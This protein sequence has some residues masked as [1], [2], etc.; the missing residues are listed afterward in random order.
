MGHAEAWE[1]YFLSWETWAT[2]TTSTRCRCLGPVVN[3]GCLADNLTR[4]LGKKNVELISESFALAN[5]LGNDLYRAPAIW[6]LL[7]QHST[8]LS[9]LRPVFPSVHFWLTHHPVLSVPF[10]WCWVLG[11]SILPSNLVSYL[12]MWRVHMS[13]SFIL[14]VLAN[15]IVPGA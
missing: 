11:L 8:G 15:G 12:S 4:D 2:S 6:W 13:G 3:C 14:Q 1:H 10:I 7:W 9:P 5:L